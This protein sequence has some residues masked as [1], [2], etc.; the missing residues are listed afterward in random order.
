MLG[1]QGLKEIA[2]ETQQSSRPDMISQ[3]QASVLGR[4]ILAFQNT[5]MQYAR[6]IE[7]A[8]KDLAAGR[9]DTKSNLAKIAYYVG[10]EDDALTEEEQIEKYGKIVTKKQTRMINGMVDT[11]LK[12]GFGLP[13]AVVSTLKNIYQE[14]EKQDAK[15]FMADHTYTVL[16]A[17]NISPPIGSK[18]RKMYGGIQTKRFEKDVIEKRGWDVTIDGKF[19]LSPS[20]SVLGSEVEAFTNIP[21]ERMVREINGIT[22]AM[23]SRNSAGQRVA[24]SLGWKTYDVGATNEEHELIKTGAKKQRK[25]EGNEK[26]KETRAKNTIEKNKKNNMCN[27]SSLFNS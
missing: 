12:G 24:L 11:T 13:G 20:Y 10:D 22:E 25:I 14:Y 17:A 2:E 8:V 23:D 16:T 27:I 19:N 9:G 1:Y 26:S 5:P 7:K 15:G 3:Q 4:I 18:L 6:L 21:L